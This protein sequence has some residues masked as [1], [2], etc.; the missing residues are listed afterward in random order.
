LSLPVASVQLRPM[1][2]YSRDFEMIAYQNGHN[3]GLYWNRGLH[4]R[5]YC[6]A[7]RLREART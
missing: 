6:Q 1:E 7:G 2:D 5:L 4:K 3:P